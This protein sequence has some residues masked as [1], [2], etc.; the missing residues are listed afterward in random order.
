MVDTS[1]IR[2][3]LSE[4]VAKGEAV[5]RLLKNK[6]FKQIVLEYYFKDTMTG[7]SHS[8]A[9]QYKPE[10]RQAITEQILSIGHLSNFLN[11]IIE[12]GN[13]A[14]TELREMEQ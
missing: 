3:E 6:D 1:V 4:T 2:K 9:N 11:M 12:D 5:Q 10:F 13:R 7:L 8:L 14:V